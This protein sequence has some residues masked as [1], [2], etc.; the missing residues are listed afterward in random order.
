MKYYQLDP[1]EKQIL[2]DFEADQFEEIE[3]DLNKYQEYAAATLSKS[4]NR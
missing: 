2:A 1:E 3:T 4:K